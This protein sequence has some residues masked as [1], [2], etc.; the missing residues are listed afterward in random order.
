MDSPTVIRR[1]DG[2]SLFIELIRTHKPG[3]LAVVLADLEREAVKGGLAYL[4]GEVTGR[5]RLRLFARYGFKC[6]KQI[7]M[8]ETEEGIQ[9][10]YEIQKEVKPDYQASFALLFAVFYVIGRLLVAWLGGAP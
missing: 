10:V 5:A 8:K 7:G 9:P 4:S 2:N 1:T 6:V 3:D